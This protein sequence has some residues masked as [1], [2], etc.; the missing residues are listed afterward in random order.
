MNL[1]EIRRDYIIFRNTIGKNNRTGNHHCLYD[2]NSQFCSFCADIFYCYECTGCDDCYF[3]VG[4][5]S[6][7]NYILN[8][9]ATDEEI[10]KLKKLIEQE[11]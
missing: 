8:K 2:Y 10:S 11:N 6:K 1:A 9:P 3:C 7:Q 4:L 5:F